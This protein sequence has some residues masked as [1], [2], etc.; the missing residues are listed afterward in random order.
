MPP[1][2]CLPRRRG[3]PPKA[4]K[5]PGETREA[6]IQAGLELLTE[7]GFSAS[8]LDEILRRV[9]VPKGSFYHYFPSKE[10]FGLELLDRYA[11]YFAERLDRFLKDESRPPRARLE[12]FG[13]HAAE[14]MAW[15][16]WRR[17]CL[18]GNLGQEMG[19]LPESFRGRLLAVFQDW[20]DRVAACLREEP[21]LAAEADRL[22][23][24]FWTGWEGAVL[25]ARLE[26]GPEPLRLFMDF[27][28]GGL[29]R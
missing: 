12:T 10:A 1:L 4:A 23:R 2:P 8:G 19:A 9:S 11:A 6:L 28:L 17:G 3:R 20:Q 25:R 5:G 16:D 14:A 18:A 22:A 21:A 29:P 7:K 24:V 13:A 27:F 26:R 15:H